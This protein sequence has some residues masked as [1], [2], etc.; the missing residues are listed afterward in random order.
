MPIS[1][2][3]NPLLKHI[4]D[5]YEENLN[6]ELRNQARDSFIACF[7]DEL[8]LENVTEVGQNG[9]SGFWM[10]LDLAENDRL[11][12]L[13]YVLTH[14]G[15]KLTLNDFRVRANFGESKGNTGVLLAV[16]AARHHHPEP[17]KFLLSHFGHE[18]T[19]D[20]LRA[21]PVRG[22]YGG[23][24]FIWWA[25]LN[26]TYGDTLAWEFIE[27]R[28][29]ENLTHEDMQV[30]SI[31]APPV[32]ALQNLCFLT[33]KHRTAWNS[34]CK[35]L[36][37]CK[38]ERLDIDYIAQDQNIPRSAKLQ[39]LIYNGISDLKNKMSKREV[40][41]QEFE[42]DVEMLTSQANDL[43]EQENKSE[44]FYLLAKLLFDTNN[45]SAERLQCYRQIKEE[46]AFFD[47]ARYEMASMLATGVYD[48]DGNELSELP[49]EKQ[50]EGKNRAY[51]EALRYV[52]SATTSTKIADVYTLKRRLVGFLLAD[53]GCVVSDK[54]SW[55]DDETDFGVLMNRITEQTVNDLT[56]QVNALTS[57]MN[58]LQ[59]RMEALEAHQGLEPPQTSDPRQR[60]LLQ[61]WSK[62]RTASDINK[63][64][65]P[66]ANDASDAIEK[67]QRAQESLKRGAKEINQPE[68]G[69]D[70]S[71]TEEARVKRR[72]TQ[73]GGADNG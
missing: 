36:I 24:T 20:D 49:L 44:G 3:N 45:F 42:F 54:Y 65:E 47:V 62:K 26:A 69:E 7:N 39:L 27:Q 70:D 48:K 29:I 66:E 8:T 53:R 59:I 11:E 2:P 25:L 32:T 19:L 12:P 17:L 55:A 52:T 68:A 37:H 38:N 4:E 56:S 34:L 30:K 50:D 21:K 41:D 5:F 61:C 71:D 9:I 15:D 46:S 57:K 13:N 43:S 58:S 10:A 40:T 14:F 18:L 72:A 64:N 22:A 31:Y 60:T 35:I 23:K 1:H 16:L 51:K 6:N 33:R 63:S 28:F 67:K 73:P